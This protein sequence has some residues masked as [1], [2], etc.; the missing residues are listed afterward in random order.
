MKST[1]STGGEV[2]LERQV[3]PCPFCG[4]QPRAPRKEGG[5]DERYGYNFIVTIFCEDCGA[6]MSRGSHRDKQGWCDDEG[7]GESEVIDA[8]NSR[9]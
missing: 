8:W 1:E 3:R 4:S 5:S 2:R 9:A 6:R 7:Q